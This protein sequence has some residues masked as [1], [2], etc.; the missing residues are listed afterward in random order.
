MDE[1]TKSLTGHWTGVYD[2]P[3]NVDEAVPFDVNLLDTAGHLTGTIHEPSTFAT[4]TTAYAN[5][6]GHYDGQNVLF[7]KEY[8]NSTDQNHYV[9]YEGTLNQVKN[10]IEGHWTTVE[11]QPWSGPFIM[12]RA[13][14]QER[15]DSLT[16]KETIDVR[17]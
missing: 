17:S 15:K 1:D 12:N 14:G 4:A 10:Q 7:I 11:E 3:D 16:A 6:T 13:L 9:R 2:Y 5:L 8:E